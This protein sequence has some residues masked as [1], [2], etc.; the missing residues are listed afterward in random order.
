MRAAQALRRSRSAATPAEQLLDAGL[1]MAELRDEDAVLAALVVEARALVGARRVLVAVATDQGFVVG[2]AH[3]PRGQNARTLLGVVAPVLEQARKTRGAALCAMP[4]TNGSAM[5]RRCVVVPL[6]A[7]ARLLAVLYADAAGAPDD[8]DDADCDALAMLAAQGASALANA[9]VIQALERKLVD[10][11]AARQGSASQ[12]GEQGP[13]SLTAEKAHLVEENQRLLK[14]NAQRN[15]ELAV[16]SA[17]EEGISAELEL[18]AIVDLVGDKLREVFR[19]GNV[20]I[21]W[22]DDKTNLVQVLYRYEHDK[23]LPL[24]PPWPLDDKGPLADMIRRREPRV[25]NTRAEQTA[26]GISPAPGTDWAHSLVGVPIIGS[27]RVLGIIGL[28][29]HDREYA[30]GPEDVRLLQ[31]IA[32]SVGGAL[33]NARLFDET[34]RLLK[35]TEQRNAELALINAIQQGI[36]AEL[37]FQAIV[38]VVGDKLREVFA[39][40]DVVI[41]WHDMQSDLIHQLYVIRNGERLLGLKPVAPSPRGAWRQMQVAHEPVIARDQQEMIAKHLLDRPSADACRSLM[42]VPILSGERMLGIIAVESF[43]REA[44]FAEA[45]VRLL[46]TVGASMGLA[47]ENVRLFNE[48]REALDRQTAMADVLEVIGRSM[49]DSRPVFE[50]IIQRCEGLFVDCAG[51]S[52][53]IVGDDGM[54][55]TAAFDFTSH[56]RSLI[57][58]E[59]EVERLLKEL[60]ERPPTPL[61]GSDT[62][63]AFQAKRPRNFTDA[64]NGADSPEGLR[65]VSR[66]IFGGRHSYSLAMVPLLKDGRGLGTISVARLRLGGFT[67]KELALLKVF[68]DQ[69]VVAIENARLFNETREALEQQTATGKVLQVMS[70]SLG[71]VQPVFEAILDSALDLCNARIGG[72]A[73]F[74]G[75]LVHLVSFKSPTPEGLAAMQASFPMKPSRGSILARAVL[76][77]DV[78]YI[79]DVL[80]DPDYE[81]KDATRKVGYRSNLAVP[82]I[83]D[84][85][86]IGSLGVCREEPSIFSEKHVRLLRMF[87]DQAVIAIENVRLF[88]ETQEALERQTATAE[89]LRVISRSPDDVRPVFEAIARSS[90]ELLGRCMTGV[91]RRAG[92]GFRLAAMFKGDQVIG[93]PDADFV[94]FDVEAN[95]PSRVFASGQM[96]H[97]PDW[98]AIELPPHEQR[99]R[100]GLGAE[101]SLMLPLMRGGEC[102]AVLFIGREEPRA[103]TA[104]EIAIAQSFVDQASI[105]IENVRLFKETQEALERQT[106]TADVL[107]VISRS[108]ADV[109]PVFDIIAQR[110]ANLTHADSGLVFRFDGELIHVASSWGMNPDGLNAARRVFPMPPGDASVTARAVRDAAVANVG[111][112]I[113]ELDDEA[114]RRLSQL[115]GNRAV[116]SVPMLHDGRVIG[117]I[118]VTR[119]SVGRFADNE[120]DLLNTFASQ[121]VI[122][123]RNS[124]LFHETREALEHQTAAAEILQV[125]SSSVADEQPVFRHIM[126]SCSR[127]FGGREQAGVAILLLDDNGMLRLSE[128]AGI[129][130]PAAG[131]APTLPLAG[132]AT[133]LA[134]RQRKVFSSADVLDD[135]QVPPAA[136]DFAE[137]MGFSY[138]LMLAPMAW[139]ERCIGSISV[140]R[141]AGERFSE[142]EQALLKTFA[143][144]AVIAI[145]NA[146]LFNETKEAL[147]QQTATAEVLRVISSSPGDVQ[148]VFDAITE[149]AM[150]LCGATMGTASRVQGDVLQLVSYRGMS[151]EGEEI[152][153]AAFPSVVSR[154]SAQGRSI[155]ER[156]PVQI[157]DVL[158]DPE[159]LLKDG[160]QRSGW[161]SILAVPL[162]LDGH[163]VGG[164]SVTRAAPGR[165]PAKSVALLETFARQAVLATENVRM[166]N[167]TREALE[168]Q[169]ATA[170]ILKV[171]ASSPDD[172]QPVMEAI[173]TSSNRLLNG[174]STAVFQ[175]LGDALHLKAFTRISDDADEALKAAFPMPLAGNP[176]AAAVGRGEVMQVPDVDVEWAANPTILEMSRRRGYRR[177]L[178]MPLMRDGV[179]VGMIS[180]TGAEP[181]LFAPHH[182]ALLQTFADQAVIAIE[183]VRL[184]NETKEALE[185]QT[186]TAAIL[187]VIAASPSDVQ[188]VL[189]AIVQSA[190]QL[191]GGF[192]ATVSRVR[193]GMLHL[194]AHTLTDAAGTAALKSR[195]PVPIDDVFIA[196]PLASRA[197]IVIEDAETDPRTAGQWRELARTRGYR[198]LL[199]VPMVREGTSIGI[200]NVTRA[201]PGTFSEHQVGL[202][203]T[204]ADQAVIAIE[205]VRLF[206][207]T[208]ESLERQTATAEIL[209]VISGSVTDTQPVFEAIVQ[210]CQRLFGG[211]AVHLAMPRGDMI[212]DVAF[213]SDTPQP[214]GVGFLK[215]WPLDRGSGAGTCILDGRVVMVADTAEGAKSFPRMHDLAIA[216][217]YRSCLF[218]PL[219]RDGNA[220]GAITILRETTGEF[221]AQEVAL[222]QTFAD[223]AV[224][225]IQNARMF[226]ETRE[227]LDRQTAT[228]DVLRVI[229]ESPTDVQ[230]V[231][232]AIANSGVRLFKGAAVAVSR[233]EAGEVRCVA[234]AEDDPQRAARWRAVFPFPLDPSYIHGA[235]LLE[236][237]VVDVAD[238]LE[239]GGRF[240][241]GKRNLAP[242]GYRAMTVV[243]MVRDRVA[244]G[245][246]AVVRVEPGP[247]SNDQIGLLETF[248]DQAVIAIENVRLFNETKEALERQTA[249]SEVL[250]VISESPTDV[251]PVL[252]TVAERAGLLCK[253][254]F[255]RIWLAEG[256]V[257]RASTTIGGDAVDGPETLPVRASSI[258]GRAFLERRV[259][260]V[261]DVVP[262]VA[263]EY[264]DV[265]ELQKRAGFRTVLAV[266]LIREGAAI[267]VI[268]LLRMRVQPFAAAEVG[269]V[270]TFADQA[271]I[272]IENVRLFNE[273]REALERQTATAEVLR[274]ISGSVTDTQPV[275]D[276]IAERS[277]R[278]TGAV[279]GWVFRFDGEWLDIGGMF[280]VNAQGV[281]AVRKLYPM[282]PGGGSAAARAVRERAVINIADVSRVSDGE[283]GVKDLAKVTGFRAVL[284]VPMLREHEVVGAISVTRSTPGLFDDK[285]IALLQTFAS[286]AVI[287]IE[288]VRLFNETQE[289]LGRQTATSDV[290][291]VISESPTDVQP[292]FDIIAER[293]VALT[294]ARYCLVTRVDGE[295]LRLVSVHGVNEIGTAALRATWPQ[296][297]RDSTSIAA[298]ALR[299]RDVVNV[300][301]LLAESDADYAPE[302]KQA[303]T[304]AGFRSGLS[305][306][307]LRDQQLIGAI[308]VNR[309]EPGL[310]ADKEIALLQTF[311]RQAV[312]AIE[313]VRLFNE[314]KEALDRQTATAEV[315]KV[316]S[317]SQTDVQPVLDAVAQRAGLLCKAEGSRVWLVAPGDRLRA[318]SY[319][320]ASKAGESGDELPIR[321]TSVVG[322]AFLERRLVH[323]EDVSPLIETEFPDARGL[324]VRSGIRTMLGVPMIREGVPIGVIGLMRTRVQPFAAADIGLV[325]TFAD[326]AVIAIENVRLFNETKEALDQQTAM[327]DVLQSI[328]SSVADPA[329]VFD[330]ILLACEHLFGG[331]RLVVFLVDDAG[332]QLRIGAIRGSDP[333]R[334]ERMRRLFPIPLAGTATA[335][336]MRDHQLLTFADVLHD[337]GVPEPVRRVAQLQGGETYAL[338]LAPM[339]WEGRAIGS[340][341]VGR[342]ELRAFDE[343]EQRLLRTFADQAV[344]AIQNARL[345]N[346]T[347]EALEH[348][349][350][351]A[352]ILSVISASVADANPVFE[353][354][355]ESCKHLFGGDELDVL[356]VDDQG[357][358]QVAAYVGKARDAVAAT[359]P[360]PVDITPAG[361]AIR[362]RRVAHYADVMNDPDTPAVLRRM[363]EIVGYHSVAFAPMVWEDRGIG[364]VGVARSRGAFSAKE[365][366]LLQTFANQAVIAIQ[367]A[368]LFRQAQEARAAAEAANEAK[369]AFLATMSHE[370][371]TPM[372]AVIGMSGLLLDTKLDPEQRDYVQ[373]VRES[374]DA[375]LTIINDILDFSK[376]EAGRMDIESHPFDLRECVESALDLVSARATEK[377]LDIAYIFE[378]DV[379]AAVSSDLTRLRQVLLNLLANAVKFT[380]HGEVVV[381][382][383]SAPASEGRVTLTFAVR[384]TGI[385]LTAEGMGRLFQSFSQADSSTTRKYGGTGLGLAISKRLAELMGGTMWVDSAGPGQGSTFLFTIDAAFADLPAARRR[386]F[387]GVQP[388]LQGK[389]LLVVDD[390]ATNRRVL[391]LQAA[392]WGMTARDTESPRE[393][394][395]WIE[396][397]ERFDVA[398]LDMHM[399]EM[400][401]LA[402]A[403]KMRAARR[404]LP[405]V[406]FSSLGRREAGDTEGLFD[407]YLAK[408]IRQSH[409]FDTLIGLFAKEP[410]APVAAAPAKPQMD[411]E[412]A[413]RH[414]LRILLA[415]DNVV[416]QKLAMRLLQQMGY[417]ADLASNGIEAVESVQRQTY[418]VVL[419]DV[420]MPELDG[421]DATRQICALM[422]APRRPRI[423]AMTANAMQGDR[424]MCIEAGMD[425]YLTKPIRVDRLVEALAAVPVRNG[426]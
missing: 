399:P 47:L 56:A 243:P 148:P 62:E 265:A 311:A 50:A 260:H 111:D 280:A 314:T 90:Y 229:S 76:A 327:A 163:A 242:A 210:S 13:K 155:L 38:D 171:I 264:P 168:R 1:R 246:I 235:A 388:E 278:L 141:P 22:W 268:A 43:G 313:N 185:R 94:P 157:E 145:Q 309:A 323:V 58:T 294:A 291:R 99:V 344:I 206:S 136:R 285:E 10:G 197:P 177:L 207:E 366:G 78:I 116:L 138:A 192:S 107:Q 383:R 403:R 322:R 63:L 385:G 298:R 412:M 367:N 415:E 407:A 69:A 413:K 220:L 252:H 21:G 68:A 158:A 219:L 245:A 32:A 15:A 215:P 384:D 175:I 400:D 187:K 382:V 81:L 425:D 386:E 350:A 37:D 174:R 122:A 85:Q 257:L 421:L 188:P 28:Q 263:T 114:V 335:Q 347:R 54:V 351:S 336:V 6:F 228:S 359:F 395:G 209:R 356:L 190:R 183:N 224:I 370:I 125:I 173:A 159:Y 179:A 354:I 269:L 201:A 275:F 196:G 387:V 39:P 319:Y 223:Q 283:Y 89:I 112:V 297:L 93:V 186:A 217:G 410:A 123:V 377:S 270:R 127:L 417:R 320:G 86:V 152:M 345:I 77:R 262:L 325:R 267:G 180:V 225:A 334:V 162:L 406:L 317:E 40:H 241:A 310:Y 160:A 302:M 231:F 60:R 258:A 52:I 8:L 402:L 25:A 271:V 59:A 233:P 284:S 293:A 390:N 203:R 61:A 72:V 2:A 256:D 253:A 380:E 200:I 236:C 57:G 84:G 198:S 321:A 405:L 132:S 191:V 176:A 80:A 88:N 205:N 153:R 31:T 318:V 105:A 103:F 150:A 364:A 358:L 34:Q 282:R 300:A 308:T 42:G 338:A 240:D 212:E 71:D 266:P 304:V 202:L 144:Q 11:G 74:D 337:D 213:A 33:E 49:T 149:R 424:E 108:V 35:E 27:N 48:T 230:P 134:M 133:E 172:V 131:A 137:R 389:R 392:K 67:E 100:A 250:K 65:R 12:L 109:Q 104:K 156:A 140:V 274:V 368:R 290:L 416:N 115:V 289:S 120:V 46:A 119:A 247:L 340:V 139:E 221:D 26:A 248:A 372:N 330:R 301:D 143:D 130:T 75:E 261:D 124:Q 128:H 303:I 329:P 7:R 341:M 129:L 117:A 306:P 305:V 113:T 96:L 91:L 121:A 142:K 324:Q 165:F 357:L 281:E 135:P 204:F 315:L 398:I 272:A 286:Q 30:Y 178:W 193:D 222:A 237:R 64:L 17:I 426:R 411:P 44:A 394:L 381:T 51:A 161:R 422:P 371:R 14:E 276:V 102:V 342:R 184:F 164:I 254:E 79:P 55:R 312:V 18:K 195:F 92:E 41:L 255:S 348:Q 154:A 287:A 244:I 189:D 169:T 170:E 420:Q 409:L 87:A 346:E 369:S 307:M 4:A 101:A 373:T 259:I 16:I 66:M 239:P 343:R 147:E 295:L 83:R 363:G 332:E 361:R 218:V 9:R 249:T 106:A 73:R 251:Q 232:D 118:T 401:G 374:G 397:G 414:P 353:K 296:R 151:R 404:E 208:K 146:R 423:V 279:A 19:T 331:D 24:P 292:V 82:L 316:I 29:N 97:I 227:A 352:E 408:P 194:V 216:L 379:P 53:A 326:Q 333:E 393:A 5:R 182:V 355:L 166:F 199:T 70:R 349:K 396:A 110:A 419:M 181:G 45:D 391:S 95:F 234:I 378:G 339:L 328:S 226:R 126:D 360:A 365:L 238:V 214:R 418:D 211:K 98:G 23:P 36:A 376:I 362:E 167:E 299:S 20:N 277:A 273:T 288:N 375:L 3:V